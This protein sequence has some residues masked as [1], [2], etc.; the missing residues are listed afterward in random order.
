MSQNTEVNFAPAK[1]DRAQQSAVA[2]L[3][4]AVG[5]LARSVTVTVPAGGPY[6]T[7]DITEWSAGVPISIPEDYGIELCIYSAAGGNGWMILRANGST[8]AITKGVGQTRGGN[9]DTTSAY[10]GVAELAGT[11]KVSAK[12]SPYVGGSRLF[13]SNTIDDAN[14][15]NCGATRASVAVGAMTSIGIGSAAGT[16]VSVGDII[17]LRIAK[18]I[19]P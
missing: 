16:A 11:G 9:F 2:A 4:L 14:A 7:F 6:S 1:L 15:I 5:P 13:I 12:L 3:A 17:T 10:L 18:D 8:A 19:R